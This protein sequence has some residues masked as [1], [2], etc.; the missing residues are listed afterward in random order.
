M[1]SRNQSLDVLRGVAILLVIGF[2]LNCGSVFRAGTVGVD[3]FFVLSGFLI[4]GLLFA[5]Y[6]RFGAIRLKRFWVR[7]AFKILP[8]VYFF[9]S[10]LFVLLRNRQM[11]PLRGF[12]ASAAFCF[13]YFEVRGPLGHTWSLSVEEHFYLLLPLLLWF[14]IRKFPDDPFR[15]L[16][17][18]FGGVVTLTFVLR[19]FNSNTDL[20]HLRIDALF[21]G[22]ALR[23][24][25]EFRSQWFQRLKAQWALISGLLFWLPAMLLL[26]HPSDVVR[27]ALYVWIELAS[28]CL[29]GWCFTHDEQRIFRSLPMRLLAGIGFYSYSIYLWQQP[30]ASYFVSFGHSPLTKLAGF[31]VC[32]GIGVL[33]ARLIEIPALRIRDRYF[34]S[35]PIDVPQFVPGGI[36]Q[37]GQ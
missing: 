30:V 6:Q 22:V 28:A 32:I 1:T 33:M 13:N 3:L 19:I 35:R 18:V 37:P 12:I 9:L 31:A 5:D 15:Y 11:F 8:P 10:V 14:L 7:R 20:T 16:L 21:T 29:V 24:L 36:L 26:S 27:S 34:N 17:P 23:Y 4:S 2:H 25:R